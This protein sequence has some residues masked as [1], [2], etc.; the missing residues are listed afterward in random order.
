MTPEAN[1]SECSELAD[2]D[3][4]DNLLG[5]PGG[6]NSGDSDRIGDAEGC[7]VI[8]PEHLRRGYERR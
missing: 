5:E 4:A 1:F 3:V 2:V 8:N 6:A 7:V